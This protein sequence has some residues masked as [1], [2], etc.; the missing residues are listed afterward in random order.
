[1]THFPDPSSLKDDEDQTAA[2]EGDLFVFPT[3]FLKL[4]SGECVITVSFHY[5]FLISLSISPHSGS[6]VRDFREIGDIAGA[7]NLEPLYLAFSTDSES[8]AIVS[9]SKN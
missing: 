8:P 2:S 3:S 5:D 9:V 6:S 1:M 4:G 7:C